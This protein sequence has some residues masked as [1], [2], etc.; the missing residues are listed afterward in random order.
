MN[1]DT[2]ANIKFDKKIINYLSVLKP[3]ATAILLAPSKTELKDIIRFT[4]LDLVL[5]KV[6]VVKHQHIKL[7]PNDA[8]ARMRTIV[9]TDKNFTSYRKSDYE[10]YFIAI[11]DEESYFQLRPYLLRI[12]HYMPLD[13]RMKKNILR[14]HKILNLFSLS[15]AFD[16]FGIFKLNKNGKKVRDELQ[17][18]FTAIDQNLATIVDE[19]PEQA[20]QL[21]SFL[22]GNIFLLKSM[23]LEI[24]EK[25]NVLI[26]QQKKTDKDAYYQLFDVFDF[27]E[28]FFSEISEEIV[29][30]LDLIEKEFNNGSRSTYDYDPIDFS[31]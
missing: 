10:K 9:E 16:S 1:I 12:Y 24:L 17:R 13:N 20:L 5:K 27:S 29:E 2:I 14:E 21:A 6:L 18:Y 25:I 31:D 8:Y 22:K 30:T 11:I 26:K 23:T 3:A 4:L 19:S 28:V 15:F 7:H